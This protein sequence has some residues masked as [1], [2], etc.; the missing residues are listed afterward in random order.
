MN[1]FTTNEKDG[2]AVIGGK[3]KPAFSGANLI[4]FGQFHFSYCLKT[5][6]C[7]SSMSEHGSQRFRRG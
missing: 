6:D 3:Q 1:A 4:E 7:D 2:V 5:S